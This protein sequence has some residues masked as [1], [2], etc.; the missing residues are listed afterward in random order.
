MFATML[1]YDSRRDWFESCKESKD[2][3]EDKEA[4]AMC[5]S[6]AVSTKLGRSRSETRTPQQVMPGSYGI[7]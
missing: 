3:A 7:T 4:S 6:C 5:S 2:E 1:T